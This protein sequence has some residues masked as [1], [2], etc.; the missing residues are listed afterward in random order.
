M[1]L[2]AIYIYNFYTEECPSYFQCKGHVNKVRSIDW[3]EN[4]MGFTSCGM[5]GNV[6]FYDLIFQKETG[7]RLNEK[8]F[9]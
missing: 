8:D 1:G 7:Q 6:Y 5:D 2:N 4:D 3:W 9:N